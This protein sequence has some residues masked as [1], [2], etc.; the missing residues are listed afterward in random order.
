[1]AVRPPKVAE[2]DGGISFRC[3]RD[4]TVSLSCCPCAFVEDASGTLSRTSDTENFATAS[5]IDRVVNKT[6]RSSQRS[7]LLTTPIYDSR[8][9]VAVHYKSINCNPQTLFDLLSICHIQFVPT[10]DTILTDIARL[11]YSLAA[12]LVKYFSVYCWCR[13]LD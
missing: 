4:D 13:A 3:H 10:F 11:H 5:R 7:S 8:R 6:R 1:M 12:F 2:T 9:V